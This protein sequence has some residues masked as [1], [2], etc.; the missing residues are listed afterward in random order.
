MHRGTFSAASVVTA[1]VGLK[2]LIASVLRATFSPAVFITPLP[3]LQIFSQQSYGKIRKFNQKRK[4][5]HSRYNR[6]FEQMIWPL[7]IIL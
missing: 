3:L 4:N 6:C 7:P 5:A 2:L 1:G